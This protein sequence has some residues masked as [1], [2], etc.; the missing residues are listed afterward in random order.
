ME[1]EI[2]GGECK[3]ATDDPLIRLRPIGF[4]SRRSKG[5]ESVLHSHLGEAF[6]LDWA[7]NKNRNKLFGQM[8]TAITDNYALRFIMTYDGA[9]AVL[10]R[11]QQR[12][13]C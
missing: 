3:F 13:M 6:A 11:L 4:G 5:R 2:A 1:A 9:N 10:L 7:I 12:F 8:F